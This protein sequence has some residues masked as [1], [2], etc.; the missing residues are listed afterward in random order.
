MRKIILLVV[1]IV[2]VHTA[3]AQESV[4]AS[5]AISAGFE[6]GIPAHNTYSI[7]LG[8]SIKG[9]LPLIPS[10]SLTA[11]AGYSYFMHKSTIFGTANKDGATIFIPLKGGLRYFLSS[12]FYVEG[13]AGTTIQSNNET[14]KRFTFAIG[15]GFIFPLGPH[16]D[17]DFGLRYEK[18]SSAALQQS[19]IR[20]A[21]RYR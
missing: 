1:A 3:R 14:A 16:S 21:Y 2:S 10:L 18:Q 15:P 19:G 7:G 20:I 4:K 11:T 5:P 12:G 17:I 9:E 8:G 6:L 13:E